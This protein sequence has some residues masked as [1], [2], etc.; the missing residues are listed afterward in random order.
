M[1]VISTE[2]L[3][4]KFFS[5]PD[6][7]RKYYLNRKAIK[8]DQLLEFEKQIGKEL[9]EMSVDDFIQFL[10]TVNFRKNKLES[11]I[12]PN[13]Y[14]LDFLITLYK[15]IINYYIDYCINN[16]YPAIKNIFYDKRL[17]CTNLAIEL[18][19]GKEIFSWEMV[20]GIIK[21]LHKD[22]TQDRAEYLELIILL[23]YCGFE[24]AAE[25]AELKEN[26]INH[27]AKTVFLIG[28]TVRLS[29][30]CYSLLTKFHEKYTFDETPKFIFCSWHDSYFK[31][32][33]A[34]NNEYNF[35]ERTL[36]DT[37]QFINAQLSKYINTPYQTQ[38]NGS[39]LYKLGFYDYLVSKYG[40]EEVNTI[41][42]ANYD[43]ERVQKLQQSANEY[44]FKYSTVSHLKRQMRM[45][46]K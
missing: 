36:L 14:S 31:F 24:N 41:L 32:I 40:E 30:R 6:W 46:I 42:L 25:I 4:R 17:S 33:V 39:N 44:G 37:R 23:Y 15:Q 29:E 21:K 26:D 1:G 22:R 5:N 8:E 3:L 38:I 34:K 19:E 13:R 2:E 9:V 12:I 27:H 11:N 18:S 20:S 16:G 28:R 35:D 43:K 7:G 10:S 45:F